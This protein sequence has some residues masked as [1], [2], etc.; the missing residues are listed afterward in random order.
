MPEEHGHEDVVVFAV[1]RRR[2]ALLMLGGVD[3]VV[4]ESI[5]E[6]R[7]DELGTPL[8]RWDPVRRVLLKQLRLQAFEV[9]GHGE[10]VPGAGKQYP[11]R[12]PR[13]LVGPRPQGV[14]DDPALHVHNEPQL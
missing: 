9:R 1:S 7:R 6:V 13:L 5:R 11:L 14:D 3:R 4:G 10:D 12:A 8:N 2:Q